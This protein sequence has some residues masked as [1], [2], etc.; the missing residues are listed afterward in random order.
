MV[1]NAREERDNALKCL[2]DC[3]ITCLDAAAQYLNRWAFTYIGIYGHSF[4][5]A[6]HK[7]GGWVGGW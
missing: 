3:L 5:E 6:G 7:V 1:E 4:T 2:V